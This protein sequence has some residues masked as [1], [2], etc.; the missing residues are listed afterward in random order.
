MGQK[1]NYAEISKDDNVY[2][3]PDVDST[4][5]NFE[6]VPQ[7]DD[8]DGDVVMLQIRTGIPS[9]VLIILATVTS[10]IIV[11]FGIYGI[12]EYVVND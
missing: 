2:D 11:A 8:E 10:M 1:I 7:E 5:N 3:S 9:Y 12:K 4:P 6:N